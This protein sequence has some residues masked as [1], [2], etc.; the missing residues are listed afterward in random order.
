VHLPAEPRATITT[1]NIV[2]RIIQEMVLATGRE[3]RHL[4]QS[5]LSGP[6]QD[7]G[8]LSHLSHSD[9]TPAIAREY[10][11]LQVTDILESDN[12]DQIIRD[13]AVTGE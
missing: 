11:R 13:L 9:L 10:L 8:S 4:A 6:I 5:Q 3:S 1:F 12:A 7:S 2:G